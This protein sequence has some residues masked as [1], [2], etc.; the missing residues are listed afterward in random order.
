[1]SS[2]V[3]IVTGGS[4]GIGA[5]V[6]RRLAAA[7]HHVLL[8][9]SQD[10]HDAAVTAKRCTTETAKVVPC[11][12][13]IA[14]P[15]SAEVVFDGAA[16]L[17][18][19]VILVNNAGVTGRISSLADSDAEAIRD[20]VDVDL[21]ATILL[22]RE[23]MIRWTDAGR[24]RQRSI[25]NLSSVAAK[26]GSPGEYVWY[27]AAK[28]GVNALTVGL[29][30][31]AASH[32]IQVNAVSPGTTATTIHARAGRPDRATEV[33]AR[34]PMGRPAQPEEIAAAVEWLVGPEASYVNGAILDVA[35]GTR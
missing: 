2:T 31:E 29:A 11:K 34:S 9:Y 13:D 16:Q 26:T 12:C 8:V 18:V 24:A 4:R 21:T 33:G 17:G 6:V 14:A 25:V 19:Q 1:M 10:D 23:A 3:A 35:G 28:A 20:A 22:C 7:G 5:A 32:G 15:G 27:A 30:V